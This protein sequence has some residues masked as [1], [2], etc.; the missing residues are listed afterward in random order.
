MTEFW[1][2]VQTGISDPKLCLVF[3]VHSLHAVMYVLIHWNSMD[4]TLADDVLKKT[5]LD[6]QITFP[7]IPCVSQVSG[8]PSLRLGIP[9]ERLSIPP[10]SR[11]GGSNT[12]WLGTWCSPLRTDSASLN[13]LESFIHF[14][15]FCSSCN[16]RIVSRPSINLLLENASQC[17]SLK[18]LQ[19]F[20]FIETFHVSFT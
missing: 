9:T 1:L 17:G 8:G 12:G 4:S 13:S 5:P 6:L 10:G 20:H 15:S 19:F 18:L 7:D 14:P 11:K 16:L 3:G 2:T